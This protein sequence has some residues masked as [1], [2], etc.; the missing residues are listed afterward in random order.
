MSNDT[1]IFLFSGAVS[2]LIVINGVLVWRYRKIHSQFDQLLAKGKIKEFKDIL[3]SQKE[4]NGEL[5]KSIKDAFLKIKG[6]EGITQRTIQKTSVVRFNPFNEM[7]G[8]QSFVIALLD[9]ND[10]GMVISSL[11]VKEGSRIYTKTIK[12]GKPDYKLSKEEQ[13]ALKKA[14][15][16]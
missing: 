6:L 4:K 13:E 11:F 3:L 10:N 12:K 16:D 15:E 1:T 9:A 5:E 7:G 2:V 8:N 14:M